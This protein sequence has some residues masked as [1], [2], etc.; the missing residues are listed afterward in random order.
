MSWNTQNLIPIGK[1]SLHINNL[2]KEDSS[3][4]TNNDRSIS[5]Y[6]QELL[7]TIRPL[8][9]LV[10]LEVAPF[11]RTVTISSLELSSQ[12]ICLLYTSPSP[13]D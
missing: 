7:D 8:D 9:S 1:T 6:H 11:Y 12:N 10:R 2:L 5:F 4:I 13:R 3:I